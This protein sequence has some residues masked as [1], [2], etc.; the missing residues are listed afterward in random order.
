[1]KKFAKQLKQ[2]KVAIKGET[3]HYMDVSIFVTGVLT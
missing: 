3:S 1:M 2:L